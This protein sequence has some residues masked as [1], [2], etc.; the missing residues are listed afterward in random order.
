MLITATAVQVTVAPDLWAALLNAIV[1]LIAALIGL[2]GLRWV[3]ERDRRARKVESLERAADERSVRSQLALERLMSVIG[4]RALELSR[5]LAEPGF[6]GYNAE[7]KLVYAEPKDANKT[8]GG[9]LDVEMQ[10]AA[11]IAAMSA[12]SADQA[13]ALE[14]AEVLY[15]FKRTLV[16]WQ[17]AKLGEVVGDI[18][19]W[20]TGALSEQEFI[21]DLRAMKTQIEEGEAYRAQTCPDHVPPLRRGV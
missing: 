11:D 13:G 7:G 9:P 16:R 3:N 4:A 6:A 15:H 17:V 10:T 8:I 19:K 20:K 5:W 12:S 18:R 14:V 2:L 21:A 1:V